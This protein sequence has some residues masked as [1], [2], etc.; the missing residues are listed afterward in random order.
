MEENQNK[1]S[2]FGENILGLLVGIPILLFIIYIVFN[3]TSLGVAVVIQFFTDYW[4]I[5]LI[6]G[7]IYLWIKMKER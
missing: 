2:T 3:V 7:V 1:K 5:L 4:H 6:I